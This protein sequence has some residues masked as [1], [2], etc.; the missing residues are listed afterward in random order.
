MFA[1]GIH[2]ALDIASRQLQP[3]E[4]LIAFLDDVYVKTTRGR[5][6]AAFDTVTGCLRNHAHIDTNLGKCRM[7]GRREAAP[8]PDVPELG[9]DVWRSDKPAQ[10]RGLKILGTP[11]GSAEFID[12]HLRARLQDQQLLLDRLVRMEDPQCAWLVLMFCASPRANHL[13]RTLPPEEAAGFAEGHDRQIWAALLILLGSPQLNGRTEQQARMIATLPRRHGGLGLQDATRSSPGAYWA[14]WADG[15]H[16]LHLRRPREAAQ[17]TALLEGQAMGRSGCVAAAEDAGRLL[18]GEGF[19]RPSWA[20]LRAGARPARNTDPDDQGELG[21]W[22]HGW[23]FHACSQRNNLFRER[24]LLP[25]LTPAGQ[26]MLRSGSGPQA[27]AW[28]Q[29]MPTCEGTRMKASIFQACLRRRLRLPLPLLHGTCGQLSGHGCRNR[30]DVLG[31]HLAACP[32]TGLLGRRA[33]PLERAWTR[34][35][36]EGGARVAHK[37]LLRDTNVPLADPA[38]QRQLD[39]VAYGVTPNGIALCCDATMVSPLT[40]QGQPIPRAAAHDGA[41]LTRAEQRKRRTYPELLHSPFGRLV[42][43][44]CEVGGRWNADA[45]RTVSDLAKHKSRG[46]PALLRPSA[47]AAWHYRWWSLLSVAAQSALAATLLA[48]GDLALGGPTG[49][50]EVPWGE[51]LEHAHLAP[52]AS[53]LPLRA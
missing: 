31:D 22:A 23:Q 17:L 4:F 45:L 36:R 12:T 40:R 26:A 39:L 53:R 10:E 9:P 21:E 47:R 32:R 25:A 38:D 37:Q 43:L 49:D 15:L 24:V 29:A 50:E 7:Y 8:P 2:D 19:R 34:V 1:L 52:P 28:L 20:A 51:V 14:A 35:T 41:A 27:G 33:N 46:A 11:V 30:I 6:R 42:I 44:A 3:D 48:E 18:Q 16:M 5:A 13:L